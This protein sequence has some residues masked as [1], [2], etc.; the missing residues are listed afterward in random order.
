M[1]T[2]N[3]NSDPI[4]KLRSLK[5]RRS[6]NGVFAVSEWT[7]NTQKPVMT[8][9]S[10]TQVSGEVNQ[11][12]SAPRSSISCNAPTPSASMPKPK[13]SNLRILIS[14]SGI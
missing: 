8:R 9:P 13:K 5:M 14:V 7:M 10:S 2:M 11:S 1:P 12:L 6:M 4:E 3:M